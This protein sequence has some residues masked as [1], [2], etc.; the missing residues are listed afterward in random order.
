VVTESRGAASLDGV[1]LD[2]ASI[3]LA[4]STIAAV[5]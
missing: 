3:R 1:M 4:E 2:V 5:E